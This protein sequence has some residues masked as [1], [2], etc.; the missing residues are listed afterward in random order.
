VKPLLRPPR[1]DRK[2]TAVSVRAETFAA[3]ADRAKRDGIAVSALVDR[4]VNAAM[5]REP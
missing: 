4:I 2:R 1:P 5:E 3:L